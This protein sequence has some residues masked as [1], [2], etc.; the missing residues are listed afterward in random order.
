MIDEHELNSIIA[1]GVCCIMWIL[2]TN[3]PW[4]LCVLADEDGVSKCSYMCG[5]FDEYIMLNP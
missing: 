2:C 5:D 1:R 4:K 3:L